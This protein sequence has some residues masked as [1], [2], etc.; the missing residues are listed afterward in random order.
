M[1][2]RKLIKR[3]TRALYVKLYWIMPL[4]VSSYFRVNKKNIIPVW[5]NNIFRR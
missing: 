4:V 2:K 1:I 3:E 5:P